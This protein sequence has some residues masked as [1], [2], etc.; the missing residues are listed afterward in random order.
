MTFSRAASFFC[1]LLLALTSLILA[2]VKGSTS[3]SI[4][5][6]F[7]THS[8]SHEIILSIRLPRTLTAFT[9]GGLLALAGSL[10]Q[11]LLRNPLADPYVLGTSGGSAIASLLLML[12]GITG[13]GLIIGTWIGSIFAILLVFVLA[14]RKQYWHSEHLILIGIALASGFSAAI[15]LIL[16]ISPDHTLRSMLFWL[17]GDLSDTSIPFLGMSIL[18]VGCGFSILFSK[19]LNI[20][21]RGEQEALALGV[22]VSRLK[23]ILFLF[24]SLFTASAVSMAGCIGF[25]GLIT[26]HLFRL[27]FGY[28]HRFLLPGSILLGGTLLT[29]ADT[30]SRILFAPQEIPIGIVMALIGIPVFLF[31][32]QK[33]I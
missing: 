31:L 4:Q 17:G 33:K 2:L 21:I 24:T 15:S 7:M 22:N 16:F 3:I 5:Q 23:I 28:D 1:L 19:D 26:P 6:M 11:V 18:F 32:L 10:M 13:A 12:C 27:L 9:T 20:L 8:L 25:V 14:H 29:L 30:L